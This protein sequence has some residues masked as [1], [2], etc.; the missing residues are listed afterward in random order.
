MLARTDAKPEE[1]KPA[2][3]QEQEAITALR[4]T[5]KYFLDQAQ[6]LAG[7]AAGSEP[8]LRMLYDGAWC[9]AD[10][11][12]FRNRRHAQADTGRSG[13]ETPG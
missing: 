13:Q 8:H 9:A 2:Q 4:E 10:G 1:I 12:R 6:Q 7:K 3:A 11:R 5:A